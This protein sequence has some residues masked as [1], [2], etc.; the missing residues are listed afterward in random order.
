MLR[1]I[2]KIKMC[3]FC[4]QWAEFSGRGLAEAV[5]VGGIVCSLCH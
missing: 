4:K 3:H 1:A 2:Y 5:N